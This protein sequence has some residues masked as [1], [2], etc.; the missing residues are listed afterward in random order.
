MFLL[1]G[2][3]PAQ[4]L[5][6][7]Q[8]LRIGALQNAGFSP[9]LDIILLSNSLEESPYVLA[10][11]KAC[12][13][14]GLECIIHHLPPDTPQE[15]LISLIR[16]LNHDPKCSALICQLPL[17]AH[18]DTETVVRIIDKNKDIDGFHPENL[19]GLALGHDDIFV[20]CT[21]AAV[22]YLLRYYNIPL[23][24][25]HVVIL[26]RSRIVGLPLHLLLSQ[27]SVGATVTLCHSQT[28]DIADFCKKAD[29]VISAMGRPHLVKA[30]WLPPDSIVV[31]VGITRIP[32]SQAPKGYILAGDVDPEAGEK[33]AALT[34]VPGGVGPLTVAMVLEN[35]IKALE[36]KLD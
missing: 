14:V 17:P 1:S 26:G 5:S 20:P 27:K 29:I 24:G 33:V 11:R 30:D 16:G 18:I 6:K 35:C 8:I 28:P 36:R 9:R 3:E 4:Q 7:K 21:P 13:A 31:D 19:G 12:T 23:S 25:K 10:K 2:K 22:L 32:D 34:P 15:E